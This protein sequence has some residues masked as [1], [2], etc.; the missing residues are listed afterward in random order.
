MAERLICLLATCCGKDA[1]GHLQ[2][3]PHVP[4]MRPN[5][6][7]GKRRATLVNTCVDS[8]NASAVAA[9][10][11]ALLLWSALHAACV[12]QVKKGAF[13]ETSYCAIECAATP[14]TAPVP[15][16]AA[17][18]EGCAAGHLAHASIAAHSHP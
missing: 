6:G 5:C 7:S 12:L 10:P 9:P 1:A 3:Q 14:N 13:Q 2:Q 17:G 4:G 11:Q 15:R 18:Q 16:S 8:F